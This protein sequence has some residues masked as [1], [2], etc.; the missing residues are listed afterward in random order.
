MRTLLSSAFSLSSA[1][2]LL[3][4]TGG[5]G[6]WGHGGVFGGRFGGRWLLLVGWRCGTGSEGRQ[7]YRTSPV[8]ARPVGLSSKCL[9]KSS[10]HVSSGISGDHSSQRPSVPAPRNATTVSACT[11]LIT[12]PVAPPH[13]IRLDNVPCRLTQLY[14]LLSAGSENP[15]L[16]VENLLR[17]ATMFIKF[18]PTIGPAIVLDDYDDAVADCGLVPRS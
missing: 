17:P 6:C 14:L 2:L 11:P 12:T 4:R 8:S 5:C 10:E 9:G 1:S 13:R 7:T 18:R 3:E 15:D 16:D